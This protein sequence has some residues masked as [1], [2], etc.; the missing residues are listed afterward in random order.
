MNIRIMKYMPTGHARTAARLRVPVAIAPRETPKSEIAATRRSG[1]PQQT[2]IPSGPLS[3][4]LPCIGQAADPSSLFTTTPVGFSAGILSSSKT[5]RSDIRS[6]LCFRQKFL[7]LLFPFHSSIRAHIDF[8]VH[9]CRIHFVRFLWINTDRRQIFKLAPC[10]S[11]GFAGIGAL[12]K[13]ISHGDVHHLRI[14][15]VYCEAIHRTVSGQTTPQLPPSEAI[16]VALEP[17]GCTG[18]EK[19]PAHACLDVDRGKNLHFSPRSV[20]HADPFSTAIGG[21]VDHVTFLPDCCM[22]FGRHVGGKG[23]AMDVKPSKGSVCLRPIV[24]AICAL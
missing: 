21:T 18:V 1:T 20:V 7:L 15:R 3:H 14:V 22:Q 8:S 24:P 2:A 17:L 10:T 11:P 5:I 16:R 4:P 9:R 23:K 13:P 19:Y 6:P 12:K